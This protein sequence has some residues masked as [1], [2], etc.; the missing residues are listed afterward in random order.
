MIDLDN[1]R[2]YYRELRCLIPGCHAPTCYAH[3]PKHRGMGGKSAGW[4]YNEGIPACRV[5][6]DALDAR[7]GAG[8]DAWK[9]H[10]QI[11][12]VVKKLAPPFWEKVKLQADAEQEAMRRVTEAQEAVRAQPIEV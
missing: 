10:M 2:F 11:L 8:K 9:T 3:W 1:C 7:N 5:H 6:H 12:D 4:A